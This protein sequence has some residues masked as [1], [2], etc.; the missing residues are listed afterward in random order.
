VKD[1]HGMFLT[2]MTALPVVLALALYVT[3]TLAYRL[4]WPNAELT[5]TDL[6]AVWQTLPLVLLSGLGMLGVDIYATIRVGKIDRTL[7][8][9]YFDQAEYWLRSWVAPVVKVFT[10]GYINPRRIVAVE[11]RKALVQASQTLNSTLGWVIL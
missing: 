2:G 11:V 3:N 1:H 9:K 10:L 4:V 8:E 7:L 6:L 5:V